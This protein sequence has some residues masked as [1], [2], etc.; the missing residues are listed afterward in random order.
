[1]EILLQMNTTR[2]FIIEKLSDMHVL[3]KD[4]VFDYLEVGNL[5]R[6]DISIS[7]T[8]ASCSPPKFYSCSYYSNTRCVTLA[9]ITVTTATVVTR[10]TGSCSS[11][12]AITAST[13]ATC[14]AAT[15]SA[16]AATMSTAPSD[17]VCLHLCVVLLAAV[18]DEVTHRL[19]VAERHTSLLVE[20]QAADGAIAPS[21]R[22]GKG[23]ASSGQRSPSSSSTSSEPSVKDEE[24]SSSD[25]PS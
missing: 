21:T 20:T 13:R 23:R 7:T 12:A 14:N 10:Y 1:M 24:S 6:Q 16:A 25:D 4:V 19:E 5:N 11:A 15:S 22:L 3:A 8:S 9:P 18:Q 17:G 2:D